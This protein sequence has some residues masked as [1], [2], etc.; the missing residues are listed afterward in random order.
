MPKPR[1]Y[2]TDGAAQHPAG[3]GQAADPLGPS[4]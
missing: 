4:H 2:V 3:T 1:R